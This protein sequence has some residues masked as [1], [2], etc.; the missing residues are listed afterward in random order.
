MSFWSIAFL[1]N[2]AIC[3]QQLKVLYLNYGMTNECQ[4]KQYIIKLPVCRGN[5]I[6][7]SLMCDVQ[8]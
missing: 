2:T 8:D 1:G 7:H 6:I 5:L 3:V 4:E